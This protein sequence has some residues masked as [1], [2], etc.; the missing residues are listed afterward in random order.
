MSD[1]DEQEIKKRMRVKVV[2]SDNI[3][4][5]FQHF[6][7]YLTGMLMI[8]VLILGIVGVFK[9]WW[10]PFKTNDEPSRTDPAIEQLLDTQ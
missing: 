2:E 7:L 8:S 6:T 4:D 9:G 5:H 10:H 3:P 1:I